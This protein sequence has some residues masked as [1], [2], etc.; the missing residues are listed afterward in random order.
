MEEFR[1]RDALSNSPGSA[2]QNGVPDV[3]RNSSLTPA[4]GYRRDVYV[5]SN[6]GKVDQG[7]CEYLAVNPGDTTWNVFLLGSP[8]T[9]P[10]P[11]P[12]LAF[13]TTNPGVANSLFVPPGF[14][15]SVMIQ[16]ATV[17][18]PPTPCSTSIISKWP[19]I[20]AWLGLYALVSA[21]TFAILKIC[22]SRWA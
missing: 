16:A 3:V 17:A 5:S 21:Q 8:G 11:Q 18:R 12:Q 15:G 1:R 6:Y 2:T 19:S 22:E 13:Q 9:P 20:A 10:A 14:V 4:V 7:N